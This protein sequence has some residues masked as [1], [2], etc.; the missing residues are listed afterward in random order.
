MTG[1]LF[2]KTALLLTIVLCIINSYSYAAKEPAIKANKLQWYELRVYTLKNSGQQKLVEDYWRHAAIA[3]YNRLGSKNIGVFTEMKPEGQTKIF[4]V[5]PF[6]NLNDFMDVTNKLSSDKTYQS[7]A[8]PYL[9]AT[10]S[11]PAY[12]RIE[13]SLL[14]AFEGM[15]A[16]QVPENKERIFELRRYESATEA[17]GK[18]KMDMFNNVGEIS[19]FKRTGLR[20]VFFAEAIIGTMR[21]NLT[22]LL[23]FKDMEDHDKGWKSFGSDA[24]WKRIRAIPGYEDAN[25]VSR[26][27]RT[28]L[29]PTAFSQ[30]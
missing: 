21:P 19:I 23:T 16:L 20:P 7:A 25:I 28:F 29:T 30:I 13:S 10:A 27:T 24:E 22:Y 6:K 17:A 1:K 18:K 11:E 2:H 3:A 12:D 14:Q 15:P 5:I 9:H 4:V 8:A 26:I